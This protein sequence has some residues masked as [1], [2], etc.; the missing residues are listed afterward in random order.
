[1][2]I[3]EK[4]KSL[5]VAKGLSQ[6]DIAHA[7][8]TTKQ[9]IYKYEHAIVTNIPLD[10]IEKM[11]KILGT[12]PANLME[13]EKPLLHSQR[14]ERENTDTLDSINEINEAIIEN[15]KSRIENLNEQI[16]IY[17]E[18]LENRKKQI[19]VCEKEIDFHKKENEYLQKRNDR[20]R[21]YLNISWILGFCAS[22]LALIVCLAHNF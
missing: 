13:W 19:E 20:L 15:Q 1:M 12:T 9:A 8:G 14:L 16:K 11:S 3:G 18:L 6:E 2:S 5:R 21:T 4:L 10:K 22:L 17:K 7:I